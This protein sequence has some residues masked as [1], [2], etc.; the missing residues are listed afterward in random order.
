MTVAVVCYGCGKRESIGDS[1]GGEFVVVVL[2][3]GLME[4]R[5]ILN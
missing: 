3:Q 5:L 4:P 1:G 2:R